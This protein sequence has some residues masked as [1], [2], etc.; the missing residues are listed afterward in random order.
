VSIALDVIDTL[1]EVPELSVS[2]LARRIGVAKS[3]AHRTCAVLAARGLLDRTQAG[4]YR[5]GLRFVEY[6]HLATERSA[7]RD[8]GLPL[9]VELRN[10]LGE[11]VQIGVPAGADVV[12][13]ERVEG[14][15]ALRYTTNSRRSPIHRSSAGK[16]L[17]A[18]NPDM[19]NA[20]VR[21]G[22]TRST[23]YTIVVPKVLIAELKRVRE[24][25]YAQSV[26]ETELGLSSLAVPVR[27]DVDGPVIAAISMVGPTT[28]VV[29][30]HEARHL[31]VLQAGAKKLG[32]A[33]G[34]GEY[35]LRRRSR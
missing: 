30:E 17:A 21:A 2:E 3:T 11:T 31:A 25:G 34:K 33:I 15:R 18:F 1:A 16:V 4:G 7:V 26:D 23:G 28:R 29:G 32:D 8:R 27:A 5:L 35:A 24:Q 19:V 10:T 20:R 9:L 22:L 6:G 13:V 12:Y 14:Q